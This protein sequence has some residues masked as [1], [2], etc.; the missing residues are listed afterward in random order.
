MDCRFPTTVSGTDRKALTSAAFWQEIDKENHCIYLSVT[1]TK[2]TVNW[3]VPERFAGP[4]YYS[5]DIP[6]IY[7]TAINNKGNIVVAALSGINEITVYTSNDA[8]T[9]AE[10]KLPAQE[11][12]LVGPRI[13]C[14]SS[15]YFILFATL[16]KEESFSLVYSTSRDG[17]S[18]SAFT[19]FNFSYPNAS[20]PLVPYV[21]SVKGGDLLVFQAHYS[22]GNRY[23]FQLFSSKSTDNGK[24]WSAPVMITGAMDDFQSYNN[25]RP[26]AI[27][28]GSNI[29]LAWER[30]LYTSV[31]TAIYVSSLNQDGTLGMDAG[32]ISI[33][34]SCINPVLFSYNGGIY[35]LW[36]DSE[37]KNN[38]AYLSKRLEL[39]W[40]D[41]TVMI[42]GVDSY[43]Y[44]ITANREKE[45]GFVWQNRTNENSFQIHRLVK[46]ASSPPPIIIPQTFEDG[47]GGN[48]D[49]ISA[50]IQEG[51]DSSGIKGFSVLWTNDP[52]ADPENTITNLPEE[53]LI[54]GNIPEDGYWYFKVKQVDYANNWSKAATVSYRRDTVAPNVP[55]IKPIEL[56][57]NNLAVSNSFSIEWLPDEGDNDIDG[58]TWSLQYVD[59][60][61]SRLAVNSR[62]PLRLSPEEVKEITDSLYEKNAEKIESLKEPPR[63]VKG[64]SLTLKETIQNARNG[65]YVFSVAAIDDVGNIGDYE[66]IQFILNKYI[67]QTYLTAVNPKTNIFGDVDLEIY[68]GGFTYEGTISEIYID[69]DGQAPYDYI[70]SQENGD[71]TVES[72]NRISGIHIN[73]PKANAYYI[74]LMHTD[75]GLYLTKDRILDI[76]DFGTVKGNK[77]FKFLPKWMTDLFHGKLSVDLSFVIVIL[78]IIFAIVAIIMITRGLT[79]TARE[80]VLIQAEIRALIQ[81]DIMPEEKKKK[82]ESLKRKRSGLRLKLTAYTMTLILILVLALIL[83]LGYIMIKREEQTRAEG[84]EERVNVILDA[85]SSGAKINLPNAASNLLAL[86]DLTEESEALSDA[87]FAVITGRGNNEDDI[88]LDYIWATNDADVSSKIN[89]D[90]LVFGSSRLVY[91]NLDQITQECLALNKQ[92]AEEVDFIAGEISELTAEGISLA[93]NDDEESIARRTEISEITTQL[94]NRVNR[95]LDDI[96]TSAIGSYPKYDSTRIDKDN[97]IFMFY[98]PVLYRHGADQTYVNGIVFVEISTEALVQDMKEAKMAII[99]L[100]SAVVIAAL[101]LG[102]IF[103]FVLSSIIVGPVNKLARH[104][105]MIRDTEDKEKLAGKDIIIKSRDEIGMLGDTINEMTH[106]LVEAAIQSKNLTFGKEVQ[107]KFIPLQTDELGNSLTYGQLNESGIELFSYYAGADELSGDYFDYKQLDKDHYAIIKCDVSGHGVPAALIMVEVATLFLNAFSN[108][109]MSNPAQGTNLRPVVGQIN[110]LIESRGFKGRFAAFTLAI[111]NIKSGECWFCNA[112]DNLV[113]V[114]DGDAMVNKTVTLPETPAAG[115]FSTDLVDMKGGYKVAKFTLK[116]DDV[117]FLYTDGIEEAKRNFRNQND[118]IV[119][120]AEDGLKDQDVHFNHKVGETN[121]EMT[122]ERVSEIIECVYSKGVYKLEKMHDANPD[123]TYTFDFSTCRGTAEESI[124]ALV[125]IEKVF[126]MYRSKNTTQEDTVM[127]DKKID[128]FLKQHFVEYSVYCLNHKEIENNNTHILYCGLMEDPQYDDLTLIAIK[129]T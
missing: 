18:W 64:D 121:E 47:K 6:N 114:Y 81:G 123:E 72:D 44:P 36:A 88:N 115:M 34:N 3:T 42:N 91:G 97:T 39:F 96:A 99:N 67:P 9:F 66:T 11:L 5:G 22:S 110:D 119:P 76:Q 14:T 7:S 38:R 92:A 98:K 71:F 116:K 89:T 84:L 16:A 61:P 25:Q 77:S 129:K 100:A 53:S 95:T 82:T 55:K 60:I 124:L 15:G 33:T 75:R 127:V 40:D 31:G 27:S 68:G 57:E 23:S 118:E 73:V 93:G 37:T 106:G 126:R 65:L 56:D 105:A 79:S 49:K 19:P 4:F 108:W 17:K 21:T 120:C 69:L 24:S 128:E 52:N 103:A 51:T 32:S 13:F 28:D 46:D 86:S 12:P 63:Y 30:S 102:L 54:E 107:T 125:S 62:H 45:L 35:L 101:I 80:A 1:S 43:V 83:A 70:L 58:Y 59:S 8:T 113:H 87:N 29:Y 122:P 109:S 2:D 26:V 90:S 112:G 10:N 48:L 74:G 20:N 50:I 117:L 78:M 111:L 104:V 41:P 85:M 94:N